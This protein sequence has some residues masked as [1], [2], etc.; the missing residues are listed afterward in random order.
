LEEYGE[1]AVE[2]V[3]AHEMTHHA[4]LQMQKFG[5]PGVESAPGTHMELEADCLAGAYANRFIRQ[6][7]DTLQI[8]AVMTHRMEHVEFL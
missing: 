4:Q 6:P 1:S 8:R 7:R 3:V 5:I 2:M